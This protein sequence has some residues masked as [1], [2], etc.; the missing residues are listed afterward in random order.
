M[1]YSMSTRSLSGSTLSQ[2]LWSGSDKDA[3]RCPTEAP[4]APAA[5]LRDGTGKHWGWAWPGIQA[6]AGPWRHKDAAW[7]CWEIPGISARQ[8]AGAVGDRDELGSLN[9]SPPSGLCWGAASQFGFPNPP[10]A[11]C[12]WREFRESESGRF[13][14]GL[15][16]AATTST[17]KMRM[18]SPRVLAN[19]A[20]AGRSLYAMVPFFLEQGREAGNVLDI[21]NSP[22]NLAGKCARS[23]TPEEVLSSLCS[24][25]VP[26]RCS[27][28]PHPEPPH[29]IPVRDLPKPT[30]SPA[31][32]SHRLKKSF[33]LIPDTQEATDNMRMV[34]PKKTWM[35]L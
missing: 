26:P 12:T 19:T 4:A 5:A 32:D 15:A 31:P 29:P 11:S 2:I 18:R 28:N 3:P 10:S 22:P 16:R 7:Q 9:P 30:L 21:P 14:L 17:P 27:P 8:R 6:G 25:L 13:Q 35:G 20:S 23:H 1:F 34:E 33:S 24:A